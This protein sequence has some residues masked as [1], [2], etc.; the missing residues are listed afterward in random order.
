MNSTEN[1][2]N[3]ANFF[4]KSGTPA[5]SKVKEH[6][7]SAGEEENMNMESHAPGKRKVEEMAQDVSIKAEQST[8]SKVKIVEDDSVKTSS[9]V[10][11]PVRKPTKRG[12]QTPT[13]KTPV[14]KESTSKIT[15][16]FA[17]K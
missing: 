16:F 12:P 9:P 14:K 11:T 15:N 10:K 7:K 6:V 8:P 13:K 1:K 5:K 4:S 3:I 2:S 17:V